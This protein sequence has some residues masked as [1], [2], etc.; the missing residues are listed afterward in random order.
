MY[1]QPGTISQT[2]QTAICCGC[3]IMFMD[4]PTN[5]AL[6]AENGFLLQNL[7]EI[8]DVFERVSQEPEILKSMSEKSYE[9]AFEELEY[10]KLLMKAMLSAGVNI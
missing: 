5:R 8:K 10:A 3:P 1:L 9:L 4:C 2:S 7:D 6:F